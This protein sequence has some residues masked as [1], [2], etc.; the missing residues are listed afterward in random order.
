MHPAVSVQ[1][2][3]YPNSDGWL[4]SFHPPPPP[5]L[6][7]PWPVCPLFFLGLLLIKAL[8]RGLRESGL[9]L[10]WWCV[11]SE[12]LLLA[13]LD[14]VWQAASAPSAHIKP[15]RFAAAA[16]SFYPLMLHLP[17]QQNQLSVIML[18]PKSLATGCAP[19]LPPLSPRRLCGPEA[20]EKPHHTNFQSEGQLY[21]Q[22]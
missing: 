7:R 15:R 4:S 20:Q 8:L 17:H 12:S 9:I 16:G 18:V 11:S 21:R 22:L 19:L 5:S 1:T 6:H 13:W 14:C 3:I 10:I 2:Q